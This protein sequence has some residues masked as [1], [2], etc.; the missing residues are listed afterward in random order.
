MTI[1]DQSGDESLKELVKVAR[2]YQFEDF[3]KQANLS[4]VMGPDEHRP[5]FYADVR[6]PF[7]FPCHTKAATYVS[8]AFFLDKKAEMHEKVRRQV[9][10]RLNKFAQHWGI[11]NSVK[12]LI[13]RDEELNKTAEYPDSSYAIVWVSEDGNKDRRYPLRNTAEVKAAADWY[14]RY[15][16]ELRQQFGFSD[17]A[18]IANKILLKAAEFGCKLGDKEELLEKCAGKGLCN[19]AQVKTLMSNRVKAAKCSKTVA[20]S[21]LALSDAFS[22][23]SASFLEPATMLQLADTIDQFDRTHHLLNKYSEAVPSP[24]DVLFSATY[25]KCAELKTSTCS[26]TTGSVYDCADFEKLSLND[27]QE[28]FG[29]DIADAVCQGL[30]LD[31]VKLAEVA[32]TFPRGEASMFD[33]LMQHKGIG[34]L[35]KRAEAHVGF[36]PAQLKQ[37]A[38]RL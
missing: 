4:E 3:A 18:T 30:K 34:K 24:E 5:S 38:S 19:P 17:R 37:F 11:T 15:L 21:M 9:E 28:V 32:A 27:I 13:K 22:R 26:L 6:Q 25:T 1:L 33:E 31:P 23:K 36:T 14:S 10:S 12:D 29:D 20:D 35:D 7:Q 16:P 8:Y 2:L